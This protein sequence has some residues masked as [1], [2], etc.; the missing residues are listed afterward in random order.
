MPHLVFHLRQCF[1]EFRIESDGGFESLQCGRYFASP[2]QCAAEISM[3]LGVVR[4]EFG[5][6]AFW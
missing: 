6:L 5:Y 4:P 3:R 2:A 1:A